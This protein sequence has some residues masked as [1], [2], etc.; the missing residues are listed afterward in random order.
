MTTR[1]QAEYHRLLLAMRLIS[2]EEVIAWADDLILRGTVPI[3]VIEVSIAIHARDDEL[4]AVLRAVRGDGDLTVAAHAALSRLKPVLDGLPLGDAIDKVVR[5]G[6][7]ARIP[8]LEQRDAT[9]FDVLYEEMV[10]GYCGS[11]PDL[12]RMLRDFLDRHAA[13]PP[14][15]RPPAPADRAGE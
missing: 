8:E 9:I 15:G 14:A 6:S 11:E 3:E 1:E 5:Y 7:S 10:A 4:D 13:E 12:R 2:R